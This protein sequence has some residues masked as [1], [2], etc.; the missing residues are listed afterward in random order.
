MTLHFYRVLKI[1]GERRFEK[2]D[3]K[4]AKNK[5]EIFSISRQIQFMYDTDNNFLKVCH[6]IL[7]ILKFLVLKSLFILHNLNKTLMKVN[8]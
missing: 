3:S 8:F 7:E 5:S 1:N 6:S 2:Y 4:N